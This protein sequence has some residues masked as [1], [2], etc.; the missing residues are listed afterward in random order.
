MHMNRRY[1]IVLSL[2]VVVGFSGSIFVETLVHA[3][4]W[5]P[6]SE[7]AVP[8]HTALAAT[9][10]NPP[11]RLLIPSLTIDAAVQQ[12]GVAIS[13]NLAVP[14]NYTDVAWYRGGP[15]PGQIGSAVMDGHTDNGFALPGV[16]KYLGEIKKGDSIY[17]VAHDGSKI[18]FVVMD[19]QIYPYQSA[20]T[21][22]IFKRNDRARLNL[23][24]C[25]GAWIAGQK[26]YNER[27]VV[28]AE[29]R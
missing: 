28:F 3:L 20:P 13:G 15:A 11:V 10:T 18:A 12:V 21:N 1:L 5:A 25:D 16:F 7:I 4:W 8:A 23:I 14:N 27:L 2:G 22:L 24:T 17:V 6:D 19:I 29:L 26:T 9:A